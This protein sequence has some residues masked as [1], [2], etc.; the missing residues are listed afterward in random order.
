MTLYAG[1][2]LPE[3]RKSIDP[4]AVG[5]NQ[6]GYSLANVGELLTAC[7]DAVR[8]RS[9]LEIGAYRGELTALLLEWADETGASIAAIDPV[10]T[11]ELRQVAEGHPELKLLEETSHDVLAR[12]DMPDAVVLDGDHNYFTLSGELRL[13]AE[14][15][16]GHLPLLLFH[17]VGWPHARRDS[18]YAPDRVPEDQRQPLAENTGL[19]PGNPG[20]DKNGLPF[21]WA[22]AREGGDRNG[23]LTAIEDFMDRGEGLRLARVPSFFGFGVLWAQDS[24]HAEALAQILDPF[25]QNPVIARLEANRVAHLIAAH[26]RGHELHQLKQ[27]LA[28]Q[29][30][31]LNS[32]AASRAFALAERLSQVRRRG[33]DPAFSKKRVE[34]VLR[35]EK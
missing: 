13:I 1:S 24:P 20:V 18:Y 23:V 31:L 8:A 30:E 33:G 16:G 27:K 2:P 11:D 9:V 25:D 15:S 28:R 34:E 19:V 10:P 7:L 35:D 3:A 5:P 26:S 6:V 14:R 21:E 22:A 32:M 4:Q 17:D 29:E 12:I